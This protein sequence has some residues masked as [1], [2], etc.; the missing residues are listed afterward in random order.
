MAKKT[1]GD[2]LAVEMNEIMRHA[3]KLIDATSDKIDDKTKEARAMLEARLAQAKVKY[4]EFEDRFRE[5]VEATDVLIHE[6]P[7]HAIGGSF[8]LGLLL[9]WLMSRK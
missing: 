8:L 9:G 1:Y 2:E 4:G 6:K 3:Q 7:Y 5:K